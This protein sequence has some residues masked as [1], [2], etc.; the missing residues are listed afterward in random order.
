[1]MYMYSLR[2]ISGVTP[3]NLLMTSMVASQLSLHVCLTRGRMLDLIGKPP[4]YKSNVLTNWSPVT[5]LYKRLIRKQLAPKLRIKW[6][7]GI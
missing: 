5:G 1:M 7:C 6:Y 4:A 2:F 3:A